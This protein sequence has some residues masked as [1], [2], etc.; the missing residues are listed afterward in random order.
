M[1]TFLLVIHLGLA[2]ALIIVVLLQRSEGGGLG[3][4][5]PSLTSGRSA[6]NAMTRTTAIL[7][8]GFFLTSIALT[9]L[10]RTSTTSSS[11]IDAI[12][13]ED[14]KTPAKATDKPAPAE[15]PKAPVVPK[16]DGP[17]VPKAE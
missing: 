3:I 7:A 14:V 5:G 6:A 15:Q 13:V 9:I 2:I 8:A 16:V 17:V 4:G 11:K 10:A 12:K 1:A